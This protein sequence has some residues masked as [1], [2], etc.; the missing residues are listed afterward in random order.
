MNQLRAA[1]EAASRTKDHFLAMLG[2]ELRNPLAPILTALQLMSLRGDDTALKEREIIDRQVRHLVRLVDDLLDVS[3]IARE[4]VDLRLQPVEMAEVVA[5]AV[6][7]ASP[8]LEERRHRLDVDVPPGLVVVGDATRLV[9]VVVNLLTNAAKYT[10]PQGHVRVTA[11]LDEG[12]VELCVTDSGIGISP[13][14]LDGV[15]EIFAQERQA[16]DRSVGGLGLGLTIVKRLVELHGGRVE[17]RSEGVERGSTF[18][19]RLPVA[20]SSDRAVHASRPLG[21]ASQNRCGSRILIV[22][23]NVDA[24]RLMAHA[25]EVVGHETRVAFDGPTALDT[26]EDFHPDAAL[27]DLGL[28]LMNGYELAQQLLA[29]MARPPVLVAVTG[30]GQPADLERTRAAGFDAHVVKPVDLQQLTELLARLLGA[31]SPR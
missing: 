16:L 23:D 26:I 13:E 11:R 5:A 18:V 19:I 31:E 14:M 25:L 27:L 9:Q 6:E 4:K 2:H 7:A 15:F 24:A 22:D 3:R 21:L 29:T 10:A 1:A 30:Y 28:P 12:Q 17:A 20:S 8:L